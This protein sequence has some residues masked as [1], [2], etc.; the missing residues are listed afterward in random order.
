MNNVFNANRFTQLFIRHTLVYY[1][2]YLMS[3]VVLMGVLSLIMGYVFYLNKGN[4]NP[5]AQFVYFVTFL[6]L[7]GSIFT[8]TIFVELNDKRR[9]IPYLMLPASNFEKFLLSW[10]YSFLIFQLFYI[11]GF[12]LIDAM[13]LGMAKPI[14]RELEIMPSSG[15]EPLPYLL[16][17][18]AFM[19]LHA[20]SFF[21][22]VFFRKMHFIRTAFI[23]F[24]LLM[25]LM[26]L[27]GFFLELLI[28]VDITS[29][30]PFGSLSFMQG[31]Q[32]LELPSVAIVNMRYY[33][34]GALAFLLWTATY[35]KLKEQEV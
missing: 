20:I 8:S 17:F 18:T 31:D 30:E 27:N 12:C 7:G 1:K 13:L 25:I 21:G 35:F 6:F 19:L 3:F 15:Q 24:G 5:A 29:A 10:I 32:R 2:A 23:L 34:M 11:V 16:A 33:L 14:P 22:A 28:G 26:V 4:V 9:A